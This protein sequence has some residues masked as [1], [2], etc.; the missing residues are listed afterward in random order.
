MQYARRIGSGA[1]HGTIIRHVLSVAATHAPRC[2]RSNP[3]L[4]CW[5]TK[6]QTQNLVSTGRPSCAMKLSSAS[7]KL[8]TDML[9]AQLTNTS[10]LPTS[11]DASRSSTWQMERP[12]C[13]PLN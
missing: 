11:A 1:C 4:F 6:S 8:G 7:N 10:A 3:T 5:I 12:S 13:C 9:S 2:G